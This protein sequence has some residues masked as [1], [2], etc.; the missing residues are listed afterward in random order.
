MLQGCHHTPLNNFID[1]KNVF[2][3]N[4]SKQLQITLATK[5]MPGHRH[6]A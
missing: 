5:P 2:A 6:S 4:S 3:G 1:P